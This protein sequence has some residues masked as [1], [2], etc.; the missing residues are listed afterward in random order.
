MDG[1]DKE[2]EGQTRPTHHWQGV[3]QTCGRSRPN[4]TAGRKRK[5]KNTTL[6][7]SHPHSEKKLI[8]IYK[9]LKSVCVCVLFV[10]SQEK[11]RERETERKEC[12]SC[13]PSSLSGF[14]LSAGDPR[15]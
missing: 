8:K 9:V 3:V 13:R 2:T 11:E 14:S 4:T 7:F 1:A 5:R 10:S 15:L 6:L 12:D